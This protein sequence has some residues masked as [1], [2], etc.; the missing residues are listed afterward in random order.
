M[1][2]FSELKLNADGL[3]PVIVQDAETKM[4][5][6][7]AWMNELAL[8]RTLN[9]KRAT[10]WSRSRQCYWIKGESSG[11]IQEVVSVHLDCD[12]DALLLGVKQTGPACHTF[13]QSC[14]FKDISTDMELKSVYLKNL[15]K[16]DGIS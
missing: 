4:V 3:I 6:M 14:F 2:K 5:L 8:S 11:H 1:V 7:M 9:T 10:Y 13:A 12:N 15:E 16:A